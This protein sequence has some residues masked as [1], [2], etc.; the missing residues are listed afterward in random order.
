MLTCSS[1]VCT[2]SD[3][4]LTHWWA[5]ETPLQ[6]CCGLWL[7]GTGRAH[8]LWLPASGL[9]TFSVTPFIFPFSG[10]TKKQLL[11]QVQPA[12]AIFS[13]QK[14]PSVLRRNSGKWVSSSSASLLQEPI[15][16]HVSRG[17]KARSINKTCQDLWT[18]WMSI[19]TCFWR[20]K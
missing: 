19:S 3:N 11:P 7:A 9:L 5:A 12:P 13:H 18:A 15:Q 20:L 1:H 8:T 17:A 16:V 14:Q 6:A 2:N 10:C 4:S